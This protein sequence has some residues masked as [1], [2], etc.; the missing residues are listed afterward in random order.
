[1]PKKADTAIG[2]AE[3]EV[4]EEEGE[5]TEKPKSKDQQ[6][7]LQG[8]RSSFSRQVSAERGSGSWSRVL[9]ERLRG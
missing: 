3:Q 6:W 2:S 8:T 5:R 7:V 1:M 9:K 4:R